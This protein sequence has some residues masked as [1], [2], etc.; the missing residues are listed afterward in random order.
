MQLPIGAGETFD[1]LS[2]SVPPS[3]FRVGVAEA[4]TVL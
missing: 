1:D 2:P 4:F 3:N